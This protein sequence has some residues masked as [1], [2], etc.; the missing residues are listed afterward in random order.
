MPT[1]D[2]Y[3]AP[4][5]DYDTCLYN[6]ETHNAVEACICNMAQRPCCQPK[7]NDTNRCLTCS[8][9]GNCARFYQSR[10]ARGVHRTIERQEGQP[11]GSPTG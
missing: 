1:I 11:S 8:A 3:A 2:V 10:D 7:A 5:A 9:C 6:N 4:R